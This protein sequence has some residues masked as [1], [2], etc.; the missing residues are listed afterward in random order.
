MPR[1]PVNVW[2]ALLAGPPG[3]HDLRAARRRLR[4]PDAPGRGGRNQH[5]ALAAAIELAGQPDACC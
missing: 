1:S 3:L 4:L 2:R 5:L